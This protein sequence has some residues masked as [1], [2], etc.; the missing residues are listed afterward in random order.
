MAGAANL[1][2]KYDEPLTADPPYRADWIWLTN[3]NQKVKVTEDKKQAGQWRR[4]TK[5]SISRLYNVGRD[6]FGACSVTSR[7]D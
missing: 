1:K 4:A 5:R 2:A 3:S 7:R 6:R